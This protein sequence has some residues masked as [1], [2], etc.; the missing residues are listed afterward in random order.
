MQ[1]KIHSLIESITNI[2]I[3]YAI[4]IASQIIIFPLFNIHVPISS[5]LK[6][7]GCFTVISVVRIYV[8]RRY[9]NRYC[10]RKKYQINDKSNIK[11]VK[12]G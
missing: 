5:N 12:E 7:G 3:G 1:S 11:P 6:I 4:A 9:F 8:I 10:L 2:A